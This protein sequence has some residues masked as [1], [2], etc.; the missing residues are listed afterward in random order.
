M[1]DTV[2][3]ASRGYLGR[4]W[5]VLPAHAKEKRPLVRYLYRRMNLPTDQEWQK[6]LE[7]YPECGIGVITGRPSGGLV[8]V[9]VDT[10]SEFKK[11]ELP[12]PMTF[13]VRSPS[14]GIHYYYRSTKSIQSGPTSWGDIKAK[15]GFVVLPPTPGYEV[16]VDADIA[17]APAWL[18]AC[19]VRPKA[20]SPFKGNARKSLGASSA[21]YEVSLDSAMRGGVQEGERVIQGCRIAFAFAR[22]GE[23]T[24]EYVRQFLVDW[25]QQ[26]KPPLTQR[27][28]ER[29]LLP[30]ARES[31]AKGASHAGYA[32]KRRRFN[33]ALRNRI[34]A[35]LKH[36][37]SR[38]QKPTVGTITTY[39]RAPAITVR[40]ELTKL[41]TDGW[42]RLETSGKGHRII[43]MGAGVES[44][45]DVRQSRSIHE[46][47]PWKP[48]RGH[49]IGRPRKCFPDEERT[50]G[51]RCASPGCQRRAVG[52]G[53]GAGYCPRHAVRERRRAR[54][55]V[56]V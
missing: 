26:N 12:V 1:R 24:W 15:G 5:F 55:L 7:R 46:V 51:R 50:T 20:K 18:E 30:K 10:E 22:R 25:N 33:R 39:M 45:T 40:Q 48:N 43:W 19:P 49:T 27:E 37:S 29:E 3:E 2:M 56:Q 6:W 32:N 16:V 11:L 52:I 53:P 23:G 47:H 35:F 31:Y 8:V 41:E 54:Q 14:G 21:S 28:V 13:A 9:D 34:I 4:G 17:C 42:L 44:L 38:S 36:A